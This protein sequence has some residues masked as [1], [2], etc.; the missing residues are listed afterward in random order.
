MNFPKRLSAIRKERLLTQQA[1][2]EVA[3]IHLS[4]Y[5]RYESGTSQ[6]TL[7]VFRKMIL[8]LNVSSDMMLFDE[9]DRGPTNDDDLL[10][11]FE[12]V[13]KLGER[14]K[15]IVKELIDSVLLK[16]D[17]KRYFKQQTQP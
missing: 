8:A 11:Q 7:E 10:L 15:E 3:G 16:H 12:A 14:E 2:A 5:K 6:P 9:G 13:S 17:A 1:M 4:Q